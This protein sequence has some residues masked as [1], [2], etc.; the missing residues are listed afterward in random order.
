MI[1]IGR[2][3]PKENLYRRFREVFGILNWISKYIASL[4][5]GQKTLRKENENHAALDQWEIDE[6]QGYN[7]A[8]TLTLFELYGK[9]L[10]LSNTCE[11][12]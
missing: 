5:Q 11:I 9:S 1:Q 7:M 8:G 4:K 6:M 2:G 12:F 3:E 10:P